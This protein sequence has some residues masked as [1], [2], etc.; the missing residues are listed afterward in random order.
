MAEDAAARSFV[1]R[2][3]PGK[4]QTVALRPEIEIRISEEQ[5]ERL[6]HAFCAAE[7]VGWEW[8]GRGNFSLDK[9]DQSA[10]GLLYLDKNHVDFQGGA[11]KLKYSDLKEEIA[12]MAFN[13]IAEQDFRQH[14]ERICAKIVHHLHRVSHESGKE[15]TKEMWDNLGAKAQA[16]INAGKEAMVPEIYNV[17]TSQAQ[18]ARG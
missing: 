6:I 16:A 3:G 15:W 12:Q 8:R 7:V 10:A 4:Y 1:S 14:E 13:M 18:N 2:V 17:L 11:D 5:F 9:L